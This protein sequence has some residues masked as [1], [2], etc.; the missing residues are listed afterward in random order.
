M[1]YVKEPPVICPECGKA[2]KS[3][4]TLRMHYLRW[5]TDAWG[6]ATQIAERAKRGYDN[7]GVVALAQKKDELTMKD[8][9][10]WA[11]EEKITEEDL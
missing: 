6:K 10:E 5:H 1:P 2:V 9:E 11:K 8:L 7:A 4:S 3:T